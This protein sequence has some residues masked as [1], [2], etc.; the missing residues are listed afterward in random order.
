MTSGLPGQL[1]PKLLYPPV[2]H[3]PLG[4]M[5]VHVCPQVMT[6]RGCTASELV[7]DDPSLVRPPLLA[8]VSFP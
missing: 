6:V 3:Y 2:P 4:K 5:E 8:A 7:R 1:T